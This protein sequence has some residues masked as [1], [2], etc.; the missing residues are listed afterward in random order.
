MSLQAVF[1]IQISQTLAFLFSSFSSAGR[2]SYL[3][4]LCNVLGMNLLK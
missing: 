1:A 3:Y 2:V 4:T